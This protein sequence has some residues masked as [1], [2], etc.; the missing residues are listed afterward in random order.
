MESLG[1]EREDW[2]RQ[3]PKVLMWLRIEPR[4]PGRDLTWHREVRITNAECVMKTSF[5]GAVL[6]CGGCDLIPP[7]R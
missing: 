7:E 2:T 5:S 3:S 6:S 4:R 1:P